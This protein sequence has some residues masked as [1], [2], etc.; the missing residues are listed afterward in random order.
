MTE[1]KFYHIVVSLCCMLVVGLI[2]VGMNLTLSK[3]DTIT[4]QL[5]R[6]NITQ[7]ELRTA[8]VSQQES[9]KGDIKVIESALRGFDKRLDALEAD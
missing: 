5:E 3:F 9:M 4:E 6:L 8:T 2:G 7:A 1:L